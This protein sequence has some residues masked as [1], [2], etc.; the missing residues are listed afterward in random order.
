MRRNDKLEKAKENIFCMRKLRWTIIS[1]IPCIDKAD[2]N[3]LE[4]G[5]KFDESMLV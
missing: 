4:I 3:A 5:V 2:D 1:G